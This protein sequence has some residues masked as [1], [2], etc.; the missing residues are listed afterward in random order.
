MSFAGVAVVVSM[1]V[2]AGA[3]VAV[4]VSL[5]VDKPVGLF[6]APRLAVEMAVK[7]AA[8]FA[9]EIAVEIAIASAMGLEGVP[10]H[11]VEAHGR[12]ALAPGVSADVRGTPWK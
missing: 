9:L 2:Y 6:V 11:C 3:G 1:D 12:S 4:C 10:R 5:S 7:M 8:E